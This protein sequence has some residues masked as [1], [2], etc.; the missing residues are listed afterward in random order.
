MSYE[1][2]VKAFTDYLT[3]K[4]YRK[5]TIKTYRRVVS[6]FLNLIQKQP[7]NITKSD[8]DDYET[9]CEK[10][11]DNSL[12]N[13]F[14]GVNKYLRYLMEYEI[15]GDKAEKWILKPPEKIQVIKHPM[16]KEQVEK[17]FKISKRNPR[18]HALFMTFYYG[19]LRRSEIIALN[20]EN[21]N[22]KERTMDILDAKGGDN[23]TINITQRCLDAIK[24]Y[25]D[26]FRE[27][28]KS[29]Y[30]K[31]LFLNEGRRISKTKMY[32]LHMEYKYMA[33]FPPNFKF[34]PHLWRTTGITHYARIETNIEILK[35]QTR[36][37]DAN[38]LLGYVA[39]ASEEYKNSYDRVFETSETKETPKPKP[40]IETKPQPPQQTPQQI[41]PEPSKGNLKTEL[42]RKLAMG[43][44]SQ[45]VYLIAIKSLEEEKANTLNYYG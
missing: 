32:N 33:R 35:K 19:M 6:T 7:E 16:T 13:R 38:T 20:I 5:E 21:I 44:I 24:N 42:V 43:E 22:F 15:L 26:N 9:F 29:G 45:E 36:H 34:H 11:S 23:K 2:E 40:V 1:K 17:I 31:F 37:R 14:A 41:Q 4:R 12:M 8:L 27:K 28:P 25:I 39:L 3:R 18:D 30:E 10:Y